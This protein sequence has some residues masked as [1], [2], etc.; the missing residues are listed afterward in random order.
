[1]FPAQSLAILYMQNLSF[2]VRRRKPNFPSLF[3]NQPENLVRV[4]VILYAEC[5]GVPGAGFQRRKFSSVAQEMVCYW[6]YLF[7]RSEVL[8]GVGVDRV[9][10]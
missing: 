4:A 3:G 9:W 7:S 2:V 1:M 8:N 6:W 10:L 5:V